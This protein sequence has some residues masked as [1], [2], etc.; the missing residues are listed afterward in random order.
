MKIKVGDVPLRVYN[1]ICNRYRNCREECPFARWGRHYYTCKGV[2]LECQDDLVEIP[3][4][5]LAG[6]TK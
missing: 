2:N 1:E 4:D 3:D 5:L 6:M